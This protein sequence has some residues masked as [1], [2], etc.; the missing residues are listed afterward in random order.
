MPK[1]FGKKV[2]ITTF[3]QEKTEMRAFQ[4]HFTFFLVFFKSFW[5]FLKMD[6]YKCPKSISEQQTQN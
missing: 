1:L 6:I 4:S 2:M 5:R 3:S